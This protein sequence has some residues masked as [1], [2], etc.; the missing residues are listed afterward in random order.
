LANCRLTNPISSFRWP[1]FKTS[2]RTDPVI[3]ARIILSAPHY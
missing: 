3:A 1:T 2:W